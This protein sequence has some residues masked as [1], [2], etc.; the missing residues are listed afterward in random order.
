MPKYI[1]NKQY[2]QLRLAQSGVLKN[3]EN[4]LDLL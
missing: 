3:I 2:V 1:H 4:M